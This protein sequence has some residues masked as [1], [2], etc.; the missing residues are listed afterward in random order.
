MNKTIA[1]IVVLA[2][3]ISTPSCK[4]AYD[5]NCKK[6][7]NGAV[8]TNTTITLDKLSKRD[9]DSECFQYGYPNNT[10]ASTYTV[11]KVLD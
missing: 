9:A 1:A 10:K 7:S 4:K 5:C 11:C 3:A 8:V 2:A 6:Y